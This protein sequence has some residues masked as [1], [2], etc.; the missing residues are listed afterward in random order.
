MGGRFSKAKRKARDKGADDG[1]GTKSTGAGGPVGTVFTYLI[2]LHGVENLSR[3]AEGKLAPFLRLFVAYPQADGARDTVVKAFSTLK[4]ENAWKDFESSD[5]TLLEEYK[6]AQTKALLALRSPKWRLDVQTR[7]E[8]RQNATSAKWREDI[9]VKLGH[10][11]VGP[12][13]VSTRVRMAMLLTLDCY[14]PSG[15]FSR[16]SR[17]S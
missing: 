4:K 14:L 1:E 12:C 9:S 17:R 2:R 3:P 5:Q 6:I 10:D 13:R 15:H 11:A 7:T 8:P 16:V